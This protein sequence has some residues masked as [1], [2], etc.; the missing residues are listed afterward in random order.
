[1]EIYRFGSRGRAEV[2][3]ETVLELA[4]RVSQGGAPAPRDAMKSW[5]RLEHVN[6]D[7]ALIDGEADGGAAGG[8]DDDYDEDG[9][10]KDEG[11]SRSKRGSRGK[12]S[13]KA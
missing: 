12:S 8:K 9:D 5:L 3:A 4:A 2:G 7:D 13:G 6:D 10:E 11:S 1:M